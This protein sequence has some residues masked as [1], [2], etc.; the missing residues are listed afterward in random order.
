[1]S[2]K[3]DSQATTLVRYVRD[4][5]EYTLGIT[6]G[7][8]PYGTKFDAPHIALM[9]RGGRNGLR[10]EL[11]QRFFDDYES[12]PSQQALADAG[13]VLEGYARRMAPRRAELRVAQ[14]RGVIYIDAGDE[15]ATVIRVEGGQWR[16]DL[17]APVLFRRTKLSGQL[18]MPH[19]R[20]DLSRLWDFVLVDDDDQALV[21][22]WLVAALVLTDVPHPI[23][24]LLT[25]HGSAKSSVTRW[26][27]DLV[28]PSAVPLRQPPRDIEGWSTAAAASWVVAVD[29]LAGALPDWL[30]DCLCR[31]STGDGYVKRQLY[32]DN[33]VAV[34]A[35]RR[36]CIINGV[37]LTIDRGDL[38]DR[39]LPVELHRPGRRVTERHL[40]ERWDAARQEIF[41]GLLRLAAAVA[42]KLS[43]ITVEDLRMADFAA[44]LAG[45]DAELGTNGLDRYR[46]R[47]ERVTLD[48]LD[49]SFINALMDKSY[50]CW[51][52]PSREILDDLTPSDK[53]WRKP[54]DWP[55]N[56]RDV[57]AQLTRHAPALRLEGWYIDH[58]E[59][60]NIRKILHWTIHPH[61]S[62]EK[63]PKRHPSDP[64][65]PSQ[66]KNRSSTTV[67]DDGSET[68]HEAGSD[69]SDPS[70]PS[71]CDARTC[72]D[73]ST[74]QTGQEYGP[75][76]VL[77]RYC[78]GEIPETMP[79]ARANG[80]CKKG[81]CIAAANNERSR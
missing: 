16:L 9:L 27:V 62:S 52:V 39:L 10:A 42:A 26:L 53:D 51:G 47:V 35:Y 43:E 65:D 18:P 78:G 69:P 49:G 24:A 61:T 59:G 60:H 58:D 22:A 32:S 56:A 71:T 1:V 72:E 45:V 57:T 80:Y 54:R 5:G 2:E 75:S 73:E 55:A 63:S 68:G 74:G 31:A 6:D 14:R 13:M 64:S 4:S 41:T 79:A 12:A 34:A 25:E 23:L 67:R 48:T 46:D 38:A 81:R 76:L 11:A 21:V 29:N 44:V 19:G 33:D 20:G 40:S 28:D 30:S 70:D 77:C 36:C 50:D 66:G 8:E 3:K 37:D 7:G 15:A 17:A